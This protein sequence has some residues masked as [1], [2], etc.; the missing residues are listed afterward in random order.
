[1]HDKK[2]MR[3]LGYIGRSELRY[4]I[5]KTRRI[6]GVTP[7]A[8]CFFGTDDHG[9]GTP[10]D[11]ESDVEAGA[12]VDGQTNSVDFG[13]YIDQ[14][15]IAVHPKL[16]LETVMDMFKKMGPRVIL[17][18]FGGKLVGLVTIKD[19]LKYITR[20]ERSELLGHDE[21]L[22]GSRLWNPRRWGFGSGDAVGWF[23]LGDGR[24]ASAAPTTR[25]ALEGEVD[26]VEMD[27]RSL[28][29]L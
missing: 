24:N 15:P 2:S 5:D 1:V 23:R 18:E 29:S 11:G 8:L 20:K 22:E 26:D 28:R 4:V 10:D 21:D 7:S 12:S 3:L 25:I 19:V 9:A 27:G 13:P 16:P 17:I 6:R 14:T